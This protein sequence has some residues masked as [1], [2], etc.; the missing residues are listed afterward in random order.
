MRCQLFSF[1][2]T[3]GDNLSSKQIW[4]PKAADTPRRLLSTIKNLTLVAP[5]G[6]PVRN[7]MTRTR[8][9]VF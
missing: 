8:S 7:Q 9:Y 6:H 4:R 1:G 2:E 3:D 5:A